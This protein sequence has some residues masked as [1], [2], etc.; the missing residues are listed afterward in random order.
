MGEPASAANGRLMA[1]AGIAEKRAVAL[2]IG[3]RASNHDGRPRVQPNANTALQR[4]PKHDFQNLH[5]VQ[6]SQAGYTS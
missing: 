2:E 3:F 6:L 1:F 4:Q 5:I